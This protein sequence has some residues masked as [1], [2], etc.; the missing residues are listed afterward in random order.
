MKKELKFILL[1][2]SMS[3]QSVFYLHAQTA[4][5]D[6][7]NYLKTP[8]APGFVLLGVEPKS[9]ETPSTPQGLASSILPAVTST[10]GINPNYAIEFSPFWLSNHPKLSFNDYFV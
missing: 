6:I 9:I 10:G 3:L 4:S 7:T 8:S 2:C 5:T 1:V